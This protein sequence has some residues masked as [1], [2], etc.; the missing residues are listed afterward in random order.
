MNRGPSPEMSRRRP[1]VRIERRE[2]VRRTIRDVR[3]GNERSA[4]G[5]PTARLRV[6]GEGSLYSLSDLWYK[7]EAIKKLP[8]DGKGSKW[9]RV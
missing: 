4:G 1:G 9:I 6:E 8:A 5:V 7:K 2:A 3:H